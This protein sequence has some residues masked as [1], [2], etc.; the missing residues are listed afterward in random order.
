VTTKAEFAVW[1]EEERRFSGTTRCITCWDQTLLSLYGGFNH[2]LVGNLQSDKGKARIDGVRSDDCDVNCVRQRPNERSL[3]IDFVLDILGIDHVCSYDASLLG[4][5]AKHLAFSGP[6]G[7][8]AH[9]GRT[10]VGMDREPGWIRWDIVGSPGTATSGAVG[11]RGEGKAVKL[12]TGSRPPSGQ[13]QPVE[14]IDI[15]G[16]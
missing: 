7:H 14:P 15:P 13:A 16:D 3:D 12:S 5:V 9:A 10:L 6:A 11:L 2:F 1:N 8:R 4:V